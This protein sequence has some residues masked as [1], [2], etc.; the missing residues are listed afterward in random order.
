M[1]SKFVKS[2]I[3]EIYLNG[4]R[5]AYV[6]VGQEQE[7]YKSIEDFYTLSPKTV[8][9]LALIEKNTGVEAINL[10]LAMSNLYHPKL[11]KGDRLFIFEDKFFNE[12][13]QKKI[14]TVFYDKAEAEKINDLNDENVNLETLKFQQE[15]KNNN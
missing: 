5:I 1:I 9:D 11:G 14:G 3:A 15:L 13:I 6:P 7:F 4:E 2:N 12:L 10:K 8:Y